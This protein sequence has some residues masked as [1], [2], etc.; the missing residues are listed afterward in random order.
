[1]KKVL[2]LYYTQTGQIEDI[3]NNV[4]KSVVNSPDIEITFEKIRPEP[5]FP[6]PWA[7]EEFFQVFPESV[8]GI[9]CNIKQLNI[10][11]TEEYDLVVIGYQPWYL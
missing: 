8:L 7:S 5:E 1:M 2:V 6:F 3:I 4:F 9:G 10:D 11:L